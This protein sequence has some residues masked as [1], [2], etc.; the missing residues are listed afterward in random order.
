MLYP[1]DAENSYGVA[2]FGE[3]GVEGVGEVTMTNHDLEDLADQFSH[4]SNDSN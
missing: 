4:K 2:S 1:S 3:G